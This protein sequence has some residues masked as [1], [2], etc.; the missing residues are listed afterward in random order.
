MAPTFE[1]KQNTAIEFLRSHF[2]DFELQLSAEGKITK[3]EYVYI[4]SLLL[5]FSC[6]RHPVSFFQNICKQF[7]ESQQHMLKTFLKS[8]VAE[9]T[10]EPKVNRSFVDDA[11]LTATKGADPLKTLAQQ[12]TRPKSASKQAMMQSKL[13]GLT[14][15]LES[16]RL[17][18]ASL[19]K[20]IEQLQQMLRRAGDQNK[21][22]LT[23]INALE[24][25]EQLCCVKLLNEI[26][27][28][29]DA[30]E[31]TKSDLLT[32]EE[33]Y[34]AQQSI[35]LKSTQECTIL[36][37]NQLT[38][39]RKE[40]AEKEK[41]WLNEFNTLREKNETIKKRFEEQKRELRI[42]FE[43]NMGKMKE[44]MLQQ[45]DLRCAQLQE[46]LAEKNER[47]LEIRKE[48]QVLLLKL[49][50]L[51][52]SKS[53]RKHLLPIPAQARLRNNLLMEDEEGEVF[54]MTYLADLKSGRCGSPEAGEDRY[55]E[56]LQRNSMLPPHLRTSYATLYPECDTAEDETRGNVSE[57]FDDSS[58]GLITRR[59]VS[60]VTSYKRPGPPTPS[61][62]AGRLSFGAA[63]PIA[64]GQIQYKEALKD[65]NINGANLAGSSDV[66]H[67]SADATMV[68][69]KTKG[70]KTPSKFKQILSS[71][72]L[73]GNFQRNENSPPKRR[74]S[75]FAKNPKY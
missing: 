23:K 70:I 64:T 68:D 25:K 22:L 75:W 50:T 53:E 7:D 9:G 21:R 65:A 62:K 6:V 66:N 61:K 27:T 16:A 29:R 1:I 41:T 28:T 45:L 39:E 17:E 18:N 5:Y 67:N 12:I 72:N 30:H 3:G 37:C 63:L 10:T 42:E 52:D 55:S 46:Q 48:N 38:K 58:T 51:E 15:Q 44:R 20:H 24:M 4:F 43:E 60:G 40:V 26:S 74:I 71:T 14:T 2:P 69:G 57:A 13:R 31:K 59:K 73:L 11:V 36:E 8:F 35:L 32:L 19:D 56:L 33:R 34:N 49:K 47:D 54:N